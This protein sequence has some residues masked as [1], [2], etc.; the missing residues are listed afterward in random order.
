MNDLS[1]DQ[2]I[3]IYDKGITLSEDDRKQKDSLLISYRSGDVLSPKIELVEAL[4]QLIEEFA[5]SIREKRTPLTDGEAALRVLRIL[6][7]ADRSIK[8]DGANVSLLAD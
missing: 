2:K 5:A 6:D 8:L 1:P 4:S 3:R 7:A